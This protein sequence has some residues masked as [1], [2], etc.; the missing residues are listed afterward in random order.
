MKIGILTFHWATNYGAVLQSYALQT[1]LENLGHTVEII[2]YKPGQYDDT[3][4]SFIRARK[5]LHFSDYLKSRKKEL[6]LVSFRNNKLKKTRRYRS[7][8]EMLGTLDYL[9]VLISGSDQVLNPF[10]LLHG[11]GQN[12]ESPTYFLGFPFEGK[13]IGYALSFGC[14]SY[15]QNALSVASKHIVGFDAISVRERSGV[16]VVKSMGRD[17]SVVVP[18]PTL[19]MHSDFYHQIADECSSSFESPYVYSFFIRNISDRKKAI[20]NT[21]HD[22]DIFW[23]NEDGDYTIQGWL[24]RI[25][26][27]E[28]V[29]TDSFHCMVMC[30]KLHKPFIIV[31][32]QKGNIG[33]NDRFYTLLGMMSL[34]SVIVN[35]DEI[36]KIQEK[37]DVSFPW[38]VVDEVLDCFQQKGED[39]LGKALL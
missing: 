29:F 5:F 19:L 31:T 37:R 30:L 6:A 38:D 15:P 26:H 18:D 7:L 22:L 34:S 36:C 24:H 27:S 28:I 3:L 32:E 39:F 17:D 10:F 23:N 16:D 13:K 1:Y 9:D 20:N 21:I 35:K 4:S 12:I 8:K 25:K 11:E 2:D 33:M 14:V